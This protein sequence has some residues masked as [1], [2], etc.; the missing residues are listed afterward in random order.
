MLGV[1]ATISVG[2]TP[3][4]LALS[5]DGARVYVAQGAGAVSVIDAATHAV[6]TT[7]HAAPHCT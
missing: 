4:D 5:P 6:M 2:A 7:S 1:V 3:L